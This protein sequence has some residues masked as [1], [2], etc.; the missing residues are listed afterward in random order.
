EHVGSV[1]ANDAPADFRAVN[2]HIVIAADALAPGD[3]VVAIEFRAGDGSL[4]RN[5]DF[6]YT[7]F[8]PARAH[9]AVPIFDQPDLK[10]RF[11]LELTVPAEWQA[12]ANGAEGSRQPAG[13]AVRVRYAE[14]EPISTYLFAFAAGRFSVETV[15]R[16]GREYR[17]FHR[18]TDAAKVA[19]NA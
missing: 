6:L 1:T 12:V 19:R 10:A 3:N 13:D 14:T 2:G 8:V 18:E 5:D 11:T 16:G 7:L 15:E 17:M 4:N 9:H